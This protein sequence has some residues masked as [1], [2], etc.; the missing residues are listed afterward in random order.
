VQWQEWFGYE[1][2]SASLPDFVSS[3][4]GFLGVLG[5]ILVL[6]QLVG[7]WRFFATG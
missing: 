4:G 2:I 5:P 1:V 6:V 3:S 7:L